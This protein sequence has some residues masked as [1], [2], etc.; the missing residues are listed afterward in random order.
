MNNNPQWVDDLS[1]FCFPENVGMTVEMGGE[2]ADVIT[3]THEKMFPCYECGSIHQCI[4]WRG[5]PHDGDGGFK[6]ASGKT[7]WLWIGC[8]LGPYQWAYEKI[9]LILIDNPMDHQ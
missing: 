1:A 3:K 4:N 8:H 5:V 2:V 6:D 7:W 9:M